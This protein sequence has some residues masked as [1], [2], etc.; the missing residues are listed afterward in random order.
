[1]EGGSTERAPALEQRE[2]RRY[3]L[4]HLRLITFSRLIRN[5]SILLTDDKDGLL[6]TKKKEK[7]DAVAG[8]GTPDIV[9]EY[10]LYFW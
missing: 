7:K 4:W 10:E 2:P 3:S 1:M 5:E 6:L 8:G 9:P